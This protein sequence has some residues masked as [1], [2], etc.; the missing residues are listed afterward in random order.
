MDG[1]VNFYSIN[2]FESPF[3]PVAHVDDSSNAPATTEVAVANADD[4][5]YCVA[6]N[7]ASDCRLDCWD[8]VKC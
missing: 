1:N 4:D 7:Y 8:Q 5:E 6:C 3:H 2:R